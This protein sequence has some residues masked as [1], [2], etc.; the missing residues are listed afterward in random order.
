MRLSQSRTHSALEVTLSTF[1]GL[2]VAVLTQLI[3]FPLFD[4]HIDL[5]TNFLIASIF[6]VISIIRSYL[7]RRLFNHLHLLGLL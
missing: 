1:I 3:V 2:V 7:I 5:D 6:T 4:I